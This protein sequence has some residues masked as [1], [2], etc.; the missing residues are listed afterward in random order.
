MDVSS[1]YT[2]LSSNEDEA[3]VSPTPEGGRLVLYP[4]NTVHETQHNT[5][6]AMGKKLL[7]LR[8]L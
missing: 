5:Q 7:R 3:R 2:N 4:D 8:H 6:L 1:S